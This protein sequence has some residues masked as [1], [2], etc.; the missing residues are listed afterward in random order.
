MNKLVHRLAYFVSLAICLACRPTPDDTIA[1]KLP[2]KST[3]TAPVTATKL[4]RTPADPPPRFVDPARRAQLESAFPA[5]EEYLAQTG[6][7][8]KLVGLTAGIVIDGELAWHHSWGSRD[9][10][11]KLPIERN[12]LFGIGSISKTFTAM[13]LLKL[14]EQ[15]RVDF[16]RPAVAYLP[17]LGRIVYPTA[18]SPEI[19][20]R[21]LLTHTSGLPRMGN[22]S[23]YPENP[24]DRA[25]FLATLQGLELE[26]APGEQ[27]VYSN[28]GFQLLGA[29][30]DGIVT[31]D[32]REYSRDEI[33]RPLGM[34]D[35][36]WMPEEAAAGQV[37]VG[38]EF[39]PDGKPRAR[40]HWRPGA[41]D[42]AGGLYAS[43]D[44]L[45]QFARFN[46][47]AWP[48]RNGS[49]RAPL[50]RATIREAHKLQALVN[51]H[52]EQG[53]AGGT[54]A[55]A[56]GTGL[57]FA[58][59]A[60]CRHDYIVGH[61]GKTLNYRAS[62]HMLPLQGVAVILLSNQSSISSRVLPANGIAVLDKL[63][64]TGALEPRRH[65]AADTLLRGA[66]GV[67]EL[68]RAWDRPAYE[69]L[70][71]EAYRDAFPIEQVRSSF[72]F[73]HTMVGNCSN[74]QPHDIVEPRAGVVELT[75][76]RGKLQIDLRVAPWSGSGITSLEF[77]GASEREPPPKYTKAAQR[78]LG[79]MTNWDDRVHARLFSEKFPAQQIHDGLRQ[80][81][82]SLGRCTLGEP[83]RRTRNAMVYGLECVRGQAS[84]HIRLSDQNDSKISG[85]EILP[86]GRACG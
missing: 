61:A 58:V 30:I 73:W 6:T 69:R 33:L 13:A 49:E 17:E 51:L 46:L 16:D 71:S 60:T 65:T 3:T 79:L 75:C 47:E 62:L 48:P 35:A 7:R 52:F 36:V 55:W 67:G 68:L 83:Q 42:A 8:D 85:F 23:E 41:A 37:A 22:F 40:P 66:A 74:P 14:R 32:H 38:H 77:V 84:L 56:A 2:A 53:S 28:L 20:I 34:N 9:P 27:R 24:P 70:F 19:T 44:D 12:T 78:A 31:T 15:G 4:V 81:E 43:L 63:A 45:V 64:D 18:D 10:E 86:T 72:T 5:I 57:A 54:E 82:Q 39:D 50:R 76:E 25:A 80:V 21:H 59:Y 26:R 29:V 1:G 11:K